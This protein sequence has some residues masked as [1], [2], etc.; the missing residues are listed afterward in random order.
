[1]AFRI[2][3]EASANLLPFRAIL[4]P[5]KYEDSG[6]LRIFL[7][8]LPG[9]VLLTLIAY[10]ALVTRAEA[11]QDDVQWRA[12][13][14]LREAGAHWAEITA[15]GREIEL[16]GAAP[17]RA[18][19]TEAVDALAALW[20]IRRVRSYAAVDPVVSPYVWRLTRSE[21]AITLSGVVP[22]KALQRR[23]RDLAQFS[24]GRPVTDETK[25]ARGAPEGDW[26][27]TVAFAIEQMAE[28]SNGEAVLEDAAL[29]LSGEARSKAA[30][31]R[32][33]KA[34]EGG[35]AE[36]FEVALKLHT[37]KPVVA[38]EERLS[39]GA[40]RRQIED[41]L[42]ERALGFGRGSAELTAQSRDLVEALAGLAKRCP[43]ARIEVAGHTDSRGDAGMNQR[44]SQAR[45]SA[46]AAALEDAGVSEDRMKAVGYGADR[47]IADNG[48]AEGRAKNRRIELTVL[49]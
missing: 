32:L 26:F 47:P 1:M 28:L 20:G 36:P 24:F 2:L 27:A 40:C 13:A 3:G 45:A 42:A 31:K 6:L 29:R 21:E 37:N 12:E 30:A 44:L 43:E 41:L 16:R 18:A 17:D 9:V 39:I 11:V 46:V 19:E 8:G 4:R 33:A 14:A 25:I 35:I 10:E 15:R 49:R 22:D 34:A 23:L 5:G 48:T 7:V 38:P